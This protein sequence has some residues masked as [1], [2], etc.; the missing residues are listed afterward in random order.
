MK[1][2]LYQPTLAVFLIAIFFLQCNNKT[3]KQE[4]HVTGLLFDVS[5]YKRVAP[6]D[7]PFG[8]ADNLPSSM[9]YST[10]MPEIGD[11][12]HQHS[13]VAWAT[14]Y[15]FKGFAEKKENGSNLKFSPS[16]VYNQINNGK[17]QG[18]F[19]ED[20]LR[21]LSQQGA[22]PWDD[23]PYI[24]SDYTTQPS[25]TVKQKAKPYCIFQWRR[26][27]TA[28]MK[29][30][31]MFL[32]AGFPI[33]IGANVDEGFQA[34]KRNGSDDY[35]WKSYSG[36]DLGGHAMLVVGFDDSKN[37][38]KVM[39]SWGRNWGNNG[40]GWIDY[41]FF[42]KAVTAGYIAYDQPTKITPDTKPDTKPDNTKPDNIVDNNVID[43]NVVDNNT[44]DPSQ[45]AK[46]S[47]SGVQVQHNVMDNTY[48]YCMKISGYIDI[49]AGFGKTF[50]ISNHFY[51]S[52]STQQAKSL[53]YPTFADVNGYAATGSI[54]YSVP[55]NGLKNYYWE[56]LMPYKALELPYE[57][58][59][60]YF[61]PTLFIDNFGY[62][63]GEAVNFSVNRKYLY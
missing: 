28:D 40:Y 12:G 30:V 62:A 53:M 37:A 34:G 55:A 22:S 43:N 10:D 61:I 60:F 18:S 23:M 16:F 17:D 1:K 45:Y 24:E 31:K 27:N 5:A 21:V 25:E 39:N 54:L 56:C 51:L 49:P 57:I 26:I 58:T 11:Q 4:E 15:A 14:A 6:A 13:C 50:Q 29:E 35:V 19:F 36:K 9:D 38:F 2:I 20:A 52:N 59:Y 41:Q 33:I 46:A 42:E 63:K 48:G 44:Y 3:G 7:L 32:N 47:L 8:A